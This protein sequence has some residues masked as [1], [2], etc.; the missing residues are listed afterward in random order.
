MRTE[1]PTD[2]HILETVSQQSF[3]SPR[4][5]A[6][7]MSNGFRY[8]GLPGNLGAVQTPFKDMLP[9]SLAHTVQD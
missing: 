5:R 8:L 4:D 6:W 1:D 3:F 7:S 9:N 2:V